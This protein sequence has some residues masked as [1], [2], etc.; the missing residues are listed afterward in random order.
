[1]SFIDSHNLIELKDILSL[2][3]QQH[4][5]TEKEMTD[6]LIKAGLAALPQAD[7]WIDEQGNKYYEVK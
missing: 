7:G 1:M 3:V 2:M 4:R 6:L 5:I